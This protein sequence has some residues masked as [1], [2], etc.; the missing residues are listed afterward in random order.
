MTLALPQPAQDRSISQKPSTPFVNRFRSYWSERADQLTIA[1]TFLTT[2]LSLFFQ[3]AAIAT[4]VPASMSLLL[5]RHKMQLQQ[6]ALQQAQTQFQA[7]IALLTVEQTQAQAQIEQKLQ[8]LSQQQ[9]RLPM[10]QERLN[11]LGHSNQK[12]AQLE[13]RIA[14][15]EQQHRQTQENPVFQ[16]A[17]ALAQTMFHQAIALRE[18]RSPQP[19]R[20]RSDRVA[21]FV[22]TAN[23]NCAAKEA[24][25]AI[26]YH[27]LLDKLREQATL[28]RATCYIGILPHHHPREILSSEFWPLGYTLVS[29]QGIRQPGGKTKANLDTEL[30]ADALTQAWSDS[31]DTAVLVSGDG[32]FVD[33]VQRLQQMGKRV[34]VVSFPQNTSNMLKKVADQ[35]RDIRQVIRE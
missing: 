3:Q 16:Q 29:K 31:Y 8:H 7:T 10:M 13:T 30:V 19:I 18:G 26:D 11:R 1:A 24:G 28:Y 12:L 9:K 22:D 27:H 32:D 2:G 4:L 25:I 5:L 33:L 17:E 34:E 6:N 14:L 20:D 15:L 21:I 35:Y 23:I